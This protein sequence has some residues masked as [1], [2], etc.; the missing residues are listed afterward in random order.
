M[1]F[2]EA[3]RERNASERGARCD[4]PHGECDIVVKLWERERPRERW[5]PTLI[6]IPSSQKR[7]Q[8]DMPKGKRA[9]TFWGICAIISRLSPTVHSYRLDIFW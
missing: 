6:V 7:Q 1:S 9:H 5:R 8:A 2:M 3:P 4:D